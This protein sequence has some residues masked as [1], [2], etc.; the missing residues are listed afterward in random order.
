MTRF[1]PSEER[2]PVLSQFPT[3]Q[4]LHLFFIHNLI[5]QLFRWQLK[6]TFEH[7]ASVRHEGKTT[8]V[9]ADIE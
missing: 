8:T 4:N 3:K 1:Y 6:S 2:T 7:V 5:K 9:Q